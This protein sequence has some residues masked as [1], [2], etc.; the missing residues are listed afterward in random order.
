MSAIYAVSAWGA[1]VA[2][3]SEQP[4]RSERSRPSELV[5]VDVK[6]LGRI[7]GGSARRPEA[8]AARASDGLLSE[9]IRHLDRVGAR[10]PRDQVV[11]ANTRKL[12]SITRQGRR[13][14]AWTV[15]RSRGSLLWAARGGMYSDEQTRTLRR[16][17]NRREARVGPYL[18]EE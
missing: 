18:C 13:P 2:S 15:A 8:R 12:R 6:R 4:A 3:G 9:G 11:V 16:L 1:S 17:T 7:E 5:Q 14:T 10:A